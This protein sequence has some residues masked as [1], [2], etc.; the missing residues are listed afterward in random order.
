M[1]LLAGNNTRIIDIDGVVEYIKTLK[2][3][4]KYYPGMV[5]DLLRMLNFDQ[6]EPNS[7]REKK[8]AV[9]LKFSC[10]LLSSVHSSQD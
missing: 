8:L 1:S 7:L 6:H 2:Q 4:P 3:D 5:D 9:S 10:C